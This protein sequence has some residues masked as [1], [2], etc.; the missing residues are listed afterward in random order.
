MA[1]MPFGTF[2][3]AEDKSQEQKNISHII[4]L[5]TDNFCIFAVGN[6][7]VYA[8]SHYV[9]FHRSILWKLPERRR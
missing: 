7:L 2:L 5:Y 6:D 9:T 1:M 3:Y 4:G 8:M